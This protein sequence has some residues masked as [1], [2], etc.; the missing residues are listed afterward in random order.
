MALLNATMHDLNALRL[1]DPDRRRTILSLYRKFCWASVL[2]RQ[3]ELIRKRDLA[4]FQA[5]LKQ[6][7]TGSAEEAME[8]EVYLVYWFASVHLLIEGWSEIGDSFTAVDSRVTT[9]HVQL[10]RRFRNATW[11]PSDYDDKRIAELVAEGHAGYAWVAEV[12]DAFAEYF[13]PIQELDRQSGNARDL[14]SQ[15]PTA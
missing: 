5:V 6:G 12:H 15:H 2:R 8:L 9:S 3:Y 13:L 10:L 7:R 4:V 14:R 11:H 1:E